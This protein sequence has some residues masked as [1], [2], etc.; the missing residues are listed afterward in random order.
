MSSREID[1][2]Y[3]RADKNNPNSYR[4]KRFDGKKS[5]KDEYTGKTIFSDSTKHTM[6]SSA[7]V[8]HVVPLCV[9]RKEYSDLTKDQQKILANIE[10][11]YVVTNSSLNRNKATGKNSLEN[12]EYVVKNGKRVA[13]K[14]KDL[15]DKGEY[16]KAKNVVDEYAKT[17]GNMLGKEAKAQANIKAH[18]AGFRA[19]NM[20]VRDEHGGSDFANSTGT[21]SFIRHSKALIEGEEDFADLSLGMVTDIVTSKT[22]SYVTTK[23]ENGM[24][25]VTTQTVECI[26]KQVDDK[27]VKEFFTKLINSP[28]FAEFS[29][30]AIKA[31]KVLFEF[32]DGKKDIEQFVYE[33]IKTGCDMVNAMI[34]AKVFRELGMTVG[35]LIGGTA[36]FYIGRF[37]GE[38]VGTL[39]GYEFLNT[40]LSLET[41]GD[42]FLRAQEELAYK[43]DQ[44]TIKLMNELAGIHA[45]HE[46]K[47]KTA[48]MGMLEGITQNNY[49]LAD[50]ALNDLCNEFGFEVEFSDQDEFDAFM[51]DKSK[52]VNMTLYH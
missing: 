23:L 6:E 48:F 45:E 30:L 25:A 26:S 29:A 2:Y 11:N 44:K 10:A 17:S 7:D 19:E 41:K 16:I 13:T 32:L 52:S 3:K 15:I 21:Q 12:H 46:E 34:G 18:A 33:S 9:I 47:M 49:A 36:G 28:E 38:F 4:N 22:E 43:I 27:A 14:A 8:D 20:V 24:T 40:I 37:V 50:S 1:N 5:T 31:G 39:I 42:I 35:G 51:L